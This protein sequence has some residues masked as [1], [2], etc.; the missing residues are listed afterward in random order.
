MTYFA[1]TFPEEL[2]IDLS[3]SH[4]RPF[5]LNAKV[6][7]QLIVCLKTKDRAGL[8][9]KRNDL[10]SQLPAFECVFKPNQWRAPVNTLCETPLIGTSIKCTF[11]KF[12]SN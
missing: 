8:D 9:M 10:L 12:A 5:E 2:V 1:L 3:S 4:L 11:N 6:M 7:N